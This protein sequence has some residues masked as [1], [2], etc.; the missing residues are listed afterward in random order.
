MFPSHR[1]SIGLAAI[2]AACALPMSLSPAHA[3]SDKHASGKELFQSRCASCHKANGEG[4]VKLG[5][6]VSADLRAPGLEDMYHHSDI[7]LLRAIMDGKDEDGEPLD[8]P[9][10]HW[11]GSLTTQQGEKI[12]GYMKTLCCH[13]DLEK[14]GD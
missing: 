6:A 13:T 7:M 12:I 9:M 10:P 2:I 1:S 8:A 14:K 3:A 4:G 11:K 5:D